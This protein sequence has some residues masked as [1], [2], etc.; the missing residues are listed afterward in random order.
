MGPTRVPA[1][2]GGS[3]LPLAVA[4]ACSKTLSLRMGFATSASLPEVG[5]SKGTLP[6]GR[7]F[8]GGS[9]DAGRGLLLEP[10]VVELAVGRPAEAGHRDHLLRRLERGEVG[11]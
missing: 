10:P 7:R 8:G 11:L 1:P 5:L 3:S 4:V 9:R 6:A 2:G